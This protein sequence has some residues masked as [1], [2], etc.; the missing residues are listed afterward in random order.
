MT[1]FTQIRSLS[2]GQRQSF[3]DLVCQL[4]RRE[5]VPNGSTFRRVEG[6][7]GD[8]GVEAYWLLPDG[9]KIGYQAKF[10]TRA[11]EIDWG[12]IDESVKQ[13]LKTHPT[14]YK[15]VIAIPCDLTDRRGTKGKGQTGWELW[16]THKATWHREW[17]APTGRE[18]E[19]IP[20][21][22]F[23]L[24]DKLAA[25]SADGLRRYW[26]GTT[27]LSSEWF[28]DHV[29][30]ATACLD[31]RYHPE[32]HVDVGIEGLFQFVARHEMALQKLQDCLSAVKQA[33]LPNHCLRGHEPEVPASSIEK[34]EATLAALI[35]IAPDFDVPCWQEWDLPHWKRLA[36]D[37]T[38]PVGEL[39]RWAWDARSKL[40]GKENE[41][42]RHDVEFIS[43]DLH[44]LN[45]SIEL[46]NNLVDSR[47]LAAEQDRA[48]LIVGRAGTGKS[49]LLGRIAELAVQEERPVVLLL[50]QQFSDQPL[51]EQ[52]TKRLGLGDYSGRVPSSP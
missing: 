21:T 7:G 28:R 52:I 39:S 12:Q 35:S 8:G 44:K 33:P 42:A 25:R 16:G 2:N 17:V 18:V 6:A 50:G 4:A 43:N 9:K 45:E 29:S 37:A 31:E 27:E 19:L 22:A 26:F 48:A 34:A 20:W 49:H 38:S 36:A 32:D 47:Y 10:F 51:W 23:V 46:F 14:L 13:A 41:K 40:S 24:R 30:L 1:D 3:E 5:S 15:Y 11:G